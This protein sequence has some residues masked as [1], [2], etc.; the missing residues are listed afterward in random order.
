MVAVVIVT[1][2]III[3]GWM[4]AT[5]ED[6]TKVKGFFQRPLGEVTLLE[7]LWWIAFITALFSSKK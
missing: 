3:L 5:P 7:F 2:I 6:I 4:S 1:V